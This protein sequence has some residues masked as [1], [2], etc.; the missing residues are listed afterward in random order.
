VPLIIVDQIGPLAGLAWLWVTIACLVKTK[1]RYAF[2]AVIALSLFDH[3]IWTQAAPYWWVL[4]GVSTT[5]TIKSDLIFRREVENSS[6]H[7]LS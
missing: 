5:S 7:T 1:W 6:S 4:V 2:I 3:Y